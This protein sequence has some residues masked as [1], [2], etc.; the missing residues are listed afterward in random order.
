MAVELWQLIQTVPGVPGNTWQEKLTN[1]GRRFYGDS[2]VGSL[3]QNLDLINRINRGDY[4][5][6][7]PAVQQTGTTASDYIKAITGG[8]RANAATQFEKILPYE[9]YLQA[10][11][12]QGIAEARVAPEEDARARQTFYNYDIA[13]TQGG[14]N[15]FGSY[16]INRGQLA[17]ELAEARSQRISSLANPLEEQF[18][19]QYQQLVDQYWKDPN[20]DVYKI[21]N[22]PKVQPT[23]QAATVTPTQPV[24][25]LYQ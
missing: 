2:Y 6:P 18:S 12:P 3:Q 21:A 10:M 22:L 4:G 14:A 13:S 19:K 1:F 24:Y 5:T 25:S 23:Q 15:R 9:Q 17:K 7:A 20:I 11:N 8:T 16:F